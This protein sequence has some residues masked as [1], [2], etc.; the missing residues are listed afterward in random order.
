MFKTT[1]LPFGRAL[2]RTVWIFV[3][4]ACAVW[5]TAQGVTPPKEKSSSDGPQFLSGILIEPSGGTYRDAAKLDRMVEELK[6]SPFDDIYIQVRAYGDAYYASQIVPRAY[7][8]SERISE[9]ES[10]DPLGRFLKA[11]KSDTKRPRRVFA[12]IIPFRVANVDRPTDANN[13]A[14]QNPDWLSMDSKFKKQDAEGN[15]YLEPGLD[16]V[17]GHLESV[18]AELASKYPVDGIL[19]DDLRY[20][21][22]AGD[23]GYHPSLLD[24]WRSQTESKDAPAPNNAAWGEIRRG[25]INACVSRMSAAAKKAR[26]EMIFAVFASA[27]NPP[28]F[29]NFSASVEYTALMQ[30]WPFWMKE[31]SVDLVVLKNY[32]AEAE[33]GGPQF[34]RWNAFAAMQVKQT[35]VEILCATAGYQN[36]SI[37]AMAQLRRAQDVGLAGAVVANFRA[38]VQDEASRELFFRAVASTIFSD[39]SKRK[40]LKET[41]MALGEGLPPKEEIPPPP[42]P[43]A[44]P[45]TLDE[46]VKGIDEKLDDRMGRFTNLIEPSDEAIG[47]LR[48]MYSNIFN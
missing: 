16:E 38:P 13:V 43:L 19:V 8:V 36:L 24:A 26:P 12:W 3:W 21:G 42:E 27:E 23:W 41:Q 7:G 46:V 4:I 32:H 30:D 35:G 29:D 20:P 44:V 11:I 22:T 2:S 5:A 1:F 34:D 33:G 37:D 47:Y 28:A 18:V 45:P 39:D 10:F 6:R 9:K 17:Q 25:A 31:K 40:P 15:Q 14:K 48:K